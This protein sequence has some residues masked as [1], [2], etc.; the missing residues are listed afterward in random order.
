VVDIV[1][2][3]NYDVVDVQVFMLPTYVCVAVWAGLGL[4]LLIGRWRALSVVAAIALPLTFAM[5]HWHRVDESKNLPAARRAAAAVATVP[6][7]SLLVASDYQT[8]QFLLYSLL[9]GGR[10]TERDVALVEDDVPIRDVARLVREGAT[11]PV[12]GRRSSEGR[13]AYAVSPR[14]LRE[15]RPLGV[16]GE[17]VGDH[18]WRLVPG[19]AGTAR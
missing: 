10:A 15:L 13:A 14:T 2:V 7:G 4:D 12:L 5:W 3:V 19:T 8:E 16:R 17:R 9:G 18:L 6:E 11:V 1:F